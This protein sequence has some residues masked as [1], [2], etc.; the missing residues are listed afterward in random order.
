MQTGKSK[1]L[2]RI[3]ASGMKHGTMR[4]ERLLCDLSQ[5]LCIYNRV[6]QRALFEKDIV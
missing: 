2:T 4:R 5:S 1:A 6:G 3:G